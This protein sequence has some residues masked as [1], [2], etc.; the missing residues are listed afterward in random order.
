MQELY[1]FVFTKATSIPFTLF[2]NV[3]KQEII[4][5]DSPIL[6]SWNDSVMMVND[7]YALGIEKFLEVSLFYLEYNYYVYIVRSWFEN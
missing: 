1:Q 2:T 6:E 7:S 4:L 3:P 5:S